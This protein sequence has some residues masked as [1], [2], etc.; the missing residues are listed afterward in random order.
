MTDEEFRALARKA[1][2]ESLPSLV[3]LMRS[4]TSKTARLQAARALKRYMYAVVQAMP[5]EAARIRQEIEATL[6]TRTS[7]GKLDS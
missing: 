6:K 5:A 4:A 3:E 1:G 7:S 2:I